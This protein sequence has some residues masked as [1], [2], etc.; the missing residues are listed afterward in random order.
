MYFVLARTS[1]RMKCK[2]VSNLESQLDGVRSKVIYTTFRLL[3]RALLLDIITSSL[4]VRT[5]CGPG[6][7]RSVILEQWRYLITL[8]YLVA[9]EYW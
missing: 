2:V 7:I 6:R 5:L 9:V 1:L 4:I 8:F 3:F